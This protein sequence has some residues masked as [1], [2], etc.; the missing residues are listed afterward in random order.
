[1]IEEQ[2]NDCHTT[3]TIPHTWITITETTLSYGLVLSKNKDLEVATGL[4]YKT[5]CS[6]NMDYNGVI[7]ELFEDAAIDSPLTSKFSKAINTQLLS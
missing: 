6:K 1:M 3:Q 7:T 4:L 5:M 2:N